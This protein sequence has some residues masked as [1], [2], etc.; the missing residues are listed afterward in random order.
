MPSNSEQ[1]FKENRDSLSTQVID[2]IKKY[3]DWRETRGVEKM[4]KTLDENLKGI[5]KQAETLQ[6][7]PHKL[8]LI[9]KTALENG[10]YI[11]GSMLHKAFTQLS[12]SPNKDPGNITHQQFKSTIQFTENV[13]IISSIHS[14]LTIQRSPAAPKGTPQTTASPQHHKNSK[15]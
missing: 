15:N 13:H 10:D 4:T 12:A 7:K 8:R 9:L 11:P 1:N 14:P 2:A 3:R 5:V 6:L